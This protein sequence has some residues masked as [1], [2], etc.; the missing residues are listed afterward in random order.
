MSFIRYQ[1][2]PEDEYP[3]FRKVREQFGFVPNLFRAQLARKD[4]LEAQMSLSAS[5]TETGALGRQQKEYI[6]LAVSARNLNTYCVTAHCEIVRMLKIEGPEPEQVAIDHTM[7][8]I[9]LRD[10][11]L[12]NFA[13]KLNEKPGEM[14]QADIDTLRTFGF[15]DAQILEAIVMTGTAQFANMLSFAL[16]TAPDFP[17]DGAVEAVAAHARPLV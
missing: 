12:I 2:L 5:A 14:T 7:T 8:K 13:I 4:L 16:G 15:T 3:P 6:F 10:K 11:A 9:P 17:N 1:D